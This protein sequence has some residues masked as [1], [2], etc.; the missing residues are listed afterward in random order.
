MKLS[1]QLMLGLFCL[2]VNLT[3]LGALTQDEAGLIEE[4]DPWPSPSPRLVRFANDLLTVKVH[5]ASVE[6]LVEEVARQS[7]LNIV[8][9]GT[10]SERDYPGFSGA[11]SGSGIGSD[12]AP[13]QF[14]PGILSGWRGSIQLR[15]TPEAVDY[16]QGSRRLWAPGRCCK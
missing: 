3:P 5:D 9:Y 1:K 15:T 13:S 12:L 7:G 8:W 11:R 10:I 16:S 4:A 2:T 6:E 14:C